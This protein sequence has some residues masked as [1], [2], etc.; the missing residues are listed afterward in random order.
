MFRRK[1]LE[2]RSRK[3]AKFQWLQ[4]IGPGKVGGSEIKSDTSASDL[5]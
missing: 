3:Q 2:I 4:D 5:R 1:M